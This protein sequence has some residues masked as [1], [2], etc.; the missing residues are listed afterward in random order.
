MA[1]KNALFAFVAGEVSPAFY[2]RADLAKHPLALAE[3]ENFFIDYKGGAFTRP[4]TEFVGP[5]PSSGPIELVRFRA[6]ADDYLL[7]FTENLMRV[8]RNGGYVL[9]AFTETLNLDSAGIAPTTHSYAIG[10]LVY[11]RGYGYARVQGAFSGEIMLWNMFDEAVEGSYSASPVYQLDTGLLTPDTCNYFQDLHRVVI[12]I[13]GQ[14]PKEL[15]Y[16]SD[17]NWSL[18]PMVENIPPA[19]TGLAG[20]PSGAGTA[21]VIYAVTAIVGGIESA[22]SSKLV[23][24][25]IVNFTATT[26]EVKLSWAA[27]PGAE[28][29]LIY[30]SIVYPTGSGDNLDQLGYLGR[31]IG[32]TYTDPNRTPDFTKTPPKRTNYFAGGNF[33]SLYCRFQQRGVYAG[34]KNEPLAIVGASQGERYAFRLNDPLLATDAFHY[35]LDAESLR[36][37]KHMLPLRSGL[38]LFTSDTV[39]QLSGGGDSRALTALNAFAETQGYVTVADVRPV[40]INLD[41]LFLTGQHSELNAMLYTEYTNSF[42]MR[43]LLALSSHLLGPNLPAIGMD[44][45]AEPHKI[46]NILREDGQLVH[47]TYERKQEVFGWSRSRTQGRFTALTSLREGANTSPYFAVRRNLGGLQV[48]T[49]ERQKPRETYDLRRQWFVDCGFENALTPGNSR[50]RLSHK[51]GAVWRFA[52]DL[53]VVLPEEPA[54]LYVAGGFFRVLSQTGSV[55][56]LGALKAPLQDDY[57]DLPTE[58]FAASKWSYGP[59]VSSMSG[60]WMLEGKRVSV[61]VDGDA[62]TGLLVDKGKVEVPQP[63]V[64]FTVGL[65]YRARLKTLPLSLGNAVFEGRPVAVRRLCTRVLDTKGLMAGPDYERMEMLPTRRQEA[66]GEVLSQHSDVV[67]SELLGGA[68]WETTAQLCFQQDY[69]LPAAVLG[70]VYDLDVGE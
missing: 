60:L 9:E 5:L 54:G 23:L 40:A 67:V 27:V 18:A 8:V 66:W 17:T 70:L 13:P 26:G 34:L 32:L 39:A 47:L 50:G 63:G 24:T 29:Y 53:P 10:Q 42:D 12:T 15:T 69:P 57:F 46:L 68:G 59:Y 16:I 65:G 14:A 62:Y 35:T 19:P 22:A 56:E 64:H 30:R 41:V 6:T 25:D 3:C 36:P 4:G 49:L 7:V 11:L 52:T 45:L 2:G 37:I 28:A 33:P 38:L 1:D 51:E 21:S 20:V 55:L 48:R 43:D 31:T 61:Q 44:W 58:G